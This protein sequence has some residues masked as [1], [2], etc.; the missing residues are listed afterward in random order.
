[1]PGNTPRKYPY[2]LPTDQVSEGASDIRALAE[3]VDADVA[4]PGGRRLEHAAG[5]D[6]PPSP[7]GQGVTASQAGAFPEAFAEAPVFVFSAR[8]LGVVLRLRQ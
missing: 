6:R 3:A 1:M 7:L 2:P 5:D 8:R 4:I